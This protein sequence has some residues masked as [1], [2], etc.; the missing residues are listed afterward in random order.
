MA[1]KV[2]K[3][4]W[5]EGGQA[6]T[7]MNGSSGRGGKVTEIERVEGRDNNERGD[8]G[9]AQGEQIEVEDCNGLS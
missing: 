1:M 6:R 5:L 7:E 8:G 4:K 2:I 9:R 3:R